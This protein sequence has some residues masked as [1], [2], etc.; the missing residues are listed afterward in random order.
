MI[1]K[2]KV[3]VNSQITAMIS[4]LESET[5]LSFLIILWY[6]K[7]TTY[8][9]LI[10]PLILH[11]VILPHAFLMNTS[12][13][14]NRIVE[15]GWKNVFKNLFRLSKSSRVNI[16][17]E[18]NPN[19]PELKSSDKTKS[20]ETTTKIATISNNLVPSKNSSNTAPGSSIL[21][22]I[23][24]NIPSKSTTSPNFVS[25][26]AKD[27]VK[28]SDS[29]KAK[30]R[31]ISSM[32][33]SEHN[34]MKYMTYFR[35]MVLLEENEVTEN[36][37]MDIEFADEPTSKSKPSIELN[38]KGKGKGKNSKVNREDDDCPDK[39][40]HTT[41]MDDQLD[42]AIELKGQLKDRMLKRM[43]LL[44]HISSLS[45]E[46]NIFYHE[47]IDQLIELEETFLEEQ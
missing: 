9:S 10:L 26:N 14:K 4:I 28:Q 36:I 35:N 41:V 3:L 37:L 32:I 12:D 38:V 15:V 17:D 18:I 11:F 34:E 29:F 45:H 5:N 2:K 25:L 22:E 30:Q 21:K 7:G 6:F 42:T 33:N 24:S 31:L 20:T 1:N 27:L 44:N 19:K 43:V 8:F 23:A 13:N 16:D 40:H 46:D 39:A 47:A